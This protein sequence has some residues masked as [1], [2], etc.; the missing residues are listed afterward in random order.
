MVSKTSKSV[1]V[2]QGN[3]RFFFS[4]IQTEHVKGTEWAKL[5]IAGKLKLVLRKAATKL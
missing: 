2:V 3:N 4:E 5:R 1:N